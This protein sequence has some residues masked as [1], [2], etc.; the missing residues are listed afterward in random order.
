MNLLCDVRC[1]AGKANKSET[2]SMDKCTYQNQ[3]KYLPFNTLLGIHYSL[4]LYLNWYFLVSIS[5]YIL[6]N[7]NNLPTGD[8]LGQYIV[9]Y[10]T[11]IK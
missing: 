2:I 1:E 9:L 3:S 7:T 8:K 6:V 11:T 4:E 10:V 5:Q